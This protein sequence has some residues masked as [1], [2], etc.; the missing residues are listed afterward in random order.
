[1][2]TTTKT[3]ALSVLLLFS[4][5]SWAVNWVS[6]D[7]SADGEIT[8]YIDRDSI[9]KD[10]NLRKAWRI[11]DLKKRDKDGEMSYRVRAEYDCKNER[12]RTLAVSTHSEGMASGQILYNAS[13][14]GSWIEIPPGTTGDSTLK[15]VC[16]R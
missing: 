5:L 14:V 12:S 15:F 7:S 13:Q 11:Q 6:I 1:M 16:A 3:I 10:G 8:V 2:K 9:R 4:S